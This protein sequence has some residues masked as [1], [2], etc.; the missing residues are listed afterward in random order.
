M[1]LFSNIKDPDTLDHL[2]TTHQT[3]TFRREINL[4]FALHT[5]FWVSPL[6]KL[7]LGINYSGNLHSS[8][9]SFSLRNLNILMTPKIEAFWLVITSPCSHTALVTLL[10]S[11]FLLHLVLKIKEPYSMAHKFHD[12]LGIFP[13][14]SL[15]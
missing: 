13:D 9:I 11:K 7:L 5:E 6:S 8:A 15:S 12:M 14:M 2:I 4:Q 1:L 10:T 3:K